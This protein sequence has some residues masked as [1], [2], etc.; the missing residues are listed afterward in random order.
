M[1]DKDYMIICY[2][3]VRNN[4]IIFAIN[5]NIINEIQQENDEIDGDGQIIKLPT[6]AKAFRTLKR[7]IT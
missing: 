3:L 7:V 1:G 4:K 5:E 6:E 2:Y